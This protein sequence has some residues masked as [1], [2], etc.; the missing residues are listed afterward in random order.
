MYVTLFWRISARRL[1][2]QTHPSQ[3]APSFA[4]SLQY[5]FASCQ[6]MA[7]DP[8][9]TLTSLRMYPRSHLL[10]QYTDY[11]PSLYNQFCIWYVVK[12]F[13]KFKDRVLK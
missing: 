5:P 3:S 11:F 10:C 1:K 9:L 8:T 4:F 6:L 7:Y 12:A 13:R 2:L